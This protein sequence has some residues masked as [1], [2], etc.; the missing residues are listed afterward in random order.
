[1]ATKYANS[2]TNWSTMTWLDAPAGSTTTAPT[3]GDDADLNGKTVTIDQTVTC[4]NIVG[5]GTLAVS[6]SRTINANVGNASAAFSCT[7]TAS[8]TVTVNGNVVGGTTASKITVNGASTTLNVNGN[9]VGGAGSVVRAITATTGTVNV[10]GNLS[11]VSNANAMLAGGATVTITGNVNGSVGTVAALNI[12]A[13]T[14]TVTGN[15][16]DGG[17]GHGSAYTQAN[18]SFTYTPTTAH[19]ATIGGKVM[20]PSRGGGRRSVP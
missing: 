12:N 5:A 1:M 16:V 11:T 13:G 14:V 8:Q 9:V 17:A 3:T 6:G 4:D 10:V 7:L 2:S 18:G 15:L 20:Y 19:T